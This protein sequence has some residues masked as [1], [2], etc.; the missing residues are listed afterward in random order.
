MLTITCADWRS[1]A[2]NEMSS[3]CTGELAFR[4]VEVHLVDKTPNLSIRSLVIKKFDTVEL[5]EDF[6]A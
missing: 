5:K 3:A 2:I 6:L 4:S 1:V